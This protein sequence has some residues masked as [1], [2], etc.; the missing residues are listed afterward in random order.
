M[1]RTLTIIFPTVITPWL[2]Q[3]GILA[4]RKAPA[5]EGAIAGELEAAAQAP[6]LDRPPVPPIKESRLGSS[7]PTMSTAGTASGHLGMPRTR[8][9]HSSDVMRLSAFCTD[10]W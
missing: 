10:C 3:M 7:Q 1:T 9:D 5:T 8:L 4:F 2:I 6:V